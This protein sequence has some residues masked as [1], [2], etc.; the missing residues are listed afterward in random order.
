MSQVFFLSSSH[1][2]SSESRTK[3]A[4]PPQLPCPSL[5]KGLSTLRAA[6][7]PQSGKI[8]LLRRAH[9]ARRAFCIIGNLSKFPIIQKVGRIFLFKKYPA[10]ICSSCLSFY[11]SKAVATFFSSSRIEICC[12]QTFSHFPHAIHA[13]AFFQPCPS[14]F[15]VYLFL[16]PPKSPYIL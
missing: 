8:S 13:D 6:A 7:I 15:H 3:W 11:P 14:V 5:L 2:Q 9:L 4:S 12:G 1:L 10:P 16:A